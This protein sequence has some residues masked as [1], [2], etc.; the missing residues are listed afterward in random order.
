[1]LKGLNIGIDSYKFDTADASLDHTIDSIATA[2]ANA[3]DSQ[4]SWSC[5]FTLSV[6]EFL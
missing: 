4:T 5:V 2:T 6:H 1:M 3:D